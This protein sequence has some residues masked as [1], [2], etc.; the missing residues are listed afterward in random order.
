MT[1]PML[2]HVTERVRASDVPC[3]ILVVVGSGFPVIT[4]TDEQPV[5][6][7][8]GTIV[9]PVNGTCESTSFDDIVVVDKTPQCA[10]INIIDQLKA[11]AR[12]PL[13]VGLLLGTTVSSNYSP[14]DWFFG[15]QKEARLVA[16]CSSGKHDR[17]F[18][19]RETFVAALKRV[20]RTEMHRSHLAQHVANVFMTRIVAMVHD[21]VR[22]AK[23]NDAPDVCNR[24]IGLV[25]KLPEFIRLLN[26]DDDFK[27]LLLDVVSFEACRLGYAFGD[28]DEE[29]AQKLD[30]RCV[31][32][33]GNHIRDTQDEDPIA[34]LSSWIKKTAR[35]SPEVFVS[36]HEELDQALADLHNE[37]N[38][39]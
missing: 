18:I 20:R 33:L 24:L 17:V 13:E 7:V 2:E 14:S 30:M 1:S 35:K 4:P 31:L 19:S 10:V 29:N 25:E 23:A 26:F 28:D 8:V 6:N 5:T 9:V 27:D 21:A 32:C 15:M 22:G 3:T 38:Q 37:M 39:L 36:I 12:A 34:N 11:C 16:L